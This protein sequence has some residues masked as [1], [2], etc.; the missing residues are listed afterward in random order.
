MDQLKPNATGTLNRAFSG[1][2][3]IVWG[4]AVFITYMIFNSGYFLE[5]IST[6]G[7]FFLGKGV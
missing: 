4:A 5:K 7:R 6:F 3:A 2:L 1:L